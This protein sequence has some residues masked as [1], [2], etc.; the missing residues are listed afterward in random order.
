VAQAVLLAGL[1]AALYA[2]GVE[3]YWIEVTR[4]H[5][6]APLEAPLTVAHI[7]DLHTYGLGRRERSLVAILEKEKPQVIVLTGDNVIDG[8][9]FGPELGLRE[10]PSYA[11][12]AEVLN[13]LHAPLG[14]WMVR[15]NWEN[16]RRVP[17]ERA[18]YE[19]SGVRLLL[20][21]GRELRSGV[22]LAGL[23]DV[24]SG[25]D[26]AAAGQ[27]IPSAAFVIGLFHSP[28][29]FDS[30]AGKWPLALAGHTHGGQIRLPFVKPLWLPEGSGS[31]VAGWYERKGSKLY[32]SRGVGTAMLPLRFLCR[33]EL[34][35]ITIGRLPTSH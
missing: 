9:L 18:F 7:A 11:R 22:W 33:P 6:Q 13:R 28:A 4:H 23:D 3:P 19:R 31:Y 5:I 20:N 15:G 26:V 8:D 10:D 2:W 29:S 32:V 27:H 17:D 35:L 21:E 24:Q 16:V 1:L 14:V 25:V 12:A 34:A 30:V